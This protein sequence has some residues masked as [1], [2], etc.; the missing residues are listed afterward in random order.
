M[1]VGTGQSFSTAL[2][3]MN[4]Q[5][6]MT[7]SDASS[8]TKTSFDLLDDFF[9]PIQWKG[10]KVSGKSSTAAATAVVELWR[11]GFCK[12]GMLKG[13]DRVRKKK[14]EGP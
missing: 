9:L 7:E 2:I 6:S 11:L 3:A 12:G 10:Y 13:K 8:S 5:F 14:E 1:V 4:S